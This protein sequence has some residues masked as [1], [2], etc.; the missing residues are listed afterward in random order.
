VTTVEK[1]PAIDWEAIER[2]YRTGTRSTREI[3]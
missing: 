1:K 3:A 2:D